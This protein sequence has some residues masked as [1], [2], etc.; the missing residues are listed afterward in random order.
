VL[1]IDLRKARG[2]KFSSFM[3]FY[4]EV[5]GIDRIGGIA[6]TDII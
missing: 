2:L 1:S 3:S 5:D 4:G 6:G